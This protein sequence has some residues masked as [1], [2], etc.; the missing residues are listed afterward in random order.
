VGGPEFH[1]AAGTQAAG[2]AFLA[3]LPGDP[4]VYVMTVHHLL[5]PMGGFR[6]LITHEEVPSFVQ[7]IQL[8]EL[9]GQPSW[10]PVTGCVVP[11]GGDPKGP[12]REL[13][14]FK[15]SGV[16]VEDAAILASVLPARGEPVW[17]IAH[18]RGGVPD[19]ELL[20]RARAVS[21][22]GDWLSCQFDN[23]NIITNGASGAPVVNTL[24]QV[25]GIYEGHS[26][27]N[28][29]KYAFVIPSPLIIETVRT[30]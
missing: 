29:Y 5:G 1:T 25:V 12:L 15:T 7:G 9:F 23:P 13:A 16:A 6:R 21:V 26:D 17:I 24:G 11:Y 3:R 19:G 8:F 18:V 4:Q 30:L 20:H 10:H 22:N 28:G 2:T 27:E 14:V